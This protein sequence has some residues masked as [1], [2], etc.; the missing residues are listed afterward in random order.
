VPTR[1]S[2]SNEESKCYEIAQTC[3]NEGIFLNAIGFGQYYDREFLKKLINIAGNG[4]LI[5]IDQVKNYSD[6]ILD[7]IKKV[8]AESSICIDIETDN[9]KLFNI[10]NSVMS[11]KIQI[12]NLDV[13]NQN[14]I[15]VI[16]SNNI[17]VDNAVL[18]VII[19]P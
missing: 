10:S 9:G 1:W 17:K 16:D 11:N 4:S 18:D 15:C 2:E 13:N 8:N 19:I 14:I 3:N 12:R 7:I 5:H 6:V